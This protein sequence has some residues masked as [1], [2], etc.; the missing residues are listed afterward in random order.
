MGHTDN[1]ATIKGYLTESYER[2]TTTGVPKRSDLTFGNTLKTMEH[3]VVFYVDMRSSR[4]V[5]KDTTEFV[6]AKVHKAFL[7]AI[8]YCVENRDGHF[9]S[10][11]G[12]G[13]L[14][15]FR[16][17]NAASRAVRA[18]MDLKAYV[19]QINDVIRSRGTSID[20]G[21]GIGQG[22]IHVVKSGKRGDD[23]TKQDLVWIGLPVYVAVELS[24]FAKSTH[25]IWISPH[26][27]TSIGQENHLNV[28]NHN[29]KSM[30]TKTTKT[31]K[32]VGLYEPR[33]TSFYS[34][35]FS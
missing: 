35:L 10:F 2:Q 15:F 27:R 16:G 28:V 26:V 18:A 7:Q 17:T 5:I 19:L 34:T 6:S 20:F 4:K 33:Y 31:L 23:Q 22:K 14:A 24:D 13:A 9:R 11:N 3:A 30:W 21:V 25:N 12:D 8:V 29:G 1:L 32:S